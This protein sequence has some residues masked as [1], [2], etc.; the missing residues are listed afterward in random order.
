RYWCGITGLQPFL[1]SRTRKSGFKPP[2]PSRRVR[3]TSMASS[4]AT[5]VPIV[6]GHEPPGLPSP[7]VFAGGESARLY[8]SSYQKP[9]VTGEP[10]VTSAASPGKESD[11]VEEVLLV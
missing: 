11:G 9:G 6:P 2:P 8:V 10:P 5:F 1:G 7:S 3:S 4:S